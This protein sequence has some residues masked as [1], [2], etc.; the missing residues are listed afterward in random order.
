MNCLEKRILADGIVK[1]GNVIRNLGYRMEALAI[2]ES[3]ND[4]TGE[5]VLRELEK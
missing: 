4:E 3:I 1:P 2:V 5:I